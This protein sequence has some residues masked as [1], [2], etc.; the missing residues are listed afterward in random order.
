M[1]RYLEIDYSKHSRAADFFRDRQDGVPFRATDLQQAAQIGF[2]RWLQM[3]MSNNLYRSVDNVVIGEGYFE[4]DV[5]RHNRSGAVV[6]TERVRREFE[7]CAPAD[8]FTPRYALEHCD[9]P[10]IQ[11]M[12]N[13]MK[14]ALAEG[15]PA[16]RMSRSGNIVFSETVQL[17]CG[18]H[19]GKYISAE[20]RCL[21]TDPEI[22]AMQMEAAGL[23]W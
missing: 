1:K 3:Q 15:H 22:A 13:A 18:W 19:G 5:H 4:A 17:P 6:S 16:V 23:E 8:A 9:N 10:D 20:H 11:R 14:R 7:W 2:N 21:S 12:Y